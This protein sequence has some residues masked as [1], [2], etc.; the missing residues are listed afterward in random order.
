MR[1]QKICGKKRK[2]R[3]RI[4]SSVLL[5]LILF[6]RGVEQNS[7]L[8]TGKILFF[9]VLFMDM[10]AQLIIKTQKIPQT[11]NSHKTYTVHF[12]TV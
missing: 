12:S 10:N 5:Q 11:I 7:F 1:R 8:F 6:L 2:R 4:K 9:L 3:K